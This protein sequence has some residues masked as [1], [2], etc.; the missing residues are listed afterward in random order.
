LS[1]RSTVIARNRSLL[2]NWFS[3]QFEFLLMMGWLLVASVVF[4]ALRFFSVGG[5]LVDWLEKLDHCAILIV[6]VLF[7]IRTVRQAIAQT[8]R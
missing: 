2:N 3:E 7:L 6:F 5:W 8:F 4:K 1:F